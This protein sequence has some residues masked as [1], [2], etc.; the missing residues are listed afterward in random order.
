MG[1]RKL[2]RIG[3]YAIMIKFVVEGKP[4]GQKRPR[5]FRRGKFMTF[6]SP[7]ENI[8]Y[9][10]KVVSAFK[11]VSP[12]IAVEGKPLFAEGIPIGVKVFAYYSQ[13][14]VSKKELAR[15]LLKYRYPLRKPDGDNVAKAILDGLTEAHAWHDDAQVVELQVFKLYDDNERV[16]VEIW[17]KNLL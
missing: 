2:Y 8:E 11:G 17:Q 9:A 4:F 16:E 12:K 6:Y 13:P 1:R 3:D 10:K 14:K 15:E 5:A 7:P